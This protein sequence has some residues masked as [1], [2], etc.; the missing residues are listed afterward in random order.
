MKDV[1]KKCEEGRQAE[2]K[3]KNEH[4]THSETQFKLFGSS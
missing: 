3:G 2:I 1:R 4:D